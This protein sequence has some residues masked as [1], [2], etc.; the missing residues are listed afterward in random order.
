MGI[1]DEPERTEIVELSE[2]EDELYRK[3]WRITILTNKKP[4]YTLG[5]C[6][7]RQ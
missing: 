3:S 6:T 5:K 2:I 4:E 1:D 7:L